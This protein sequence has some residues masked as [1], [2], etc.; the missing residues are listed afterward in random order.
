MKDD[1]IKI[2]CSSEDKA[3]IQKKAEEKGISVSAY[4]IDQAFKSDADSVIPVKP[5]ELSQC[6]YKGLTF[7][8]NLEVDE[9][10]FIVVGRMYKDRAEIKTGYKLIF[11][12]G[13]DDIKTFLDESKAVVAVNRWMLSMDIKGSNPFSKFF[14]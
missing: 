7:R 3:A 14:E 1:S 12:R 9:G 13:R 4:L 8:F 5:M 6:Y 2:R 11:G 10:E